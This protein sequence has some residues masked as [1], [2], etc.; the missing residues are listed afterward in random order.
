MRS[1]KVGEA[2]HFPNPWTSGILKLL[3]EVLLM[4]PSEKYV[5]VHYEIE[6]LFNH[7]RV[8]VNDISTSTLLKER[9]G[10]GNDVKGD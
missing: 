7:L 5:S 3:K 1:C 8:K 4:T 2:Y 9:S 10:E 6:S